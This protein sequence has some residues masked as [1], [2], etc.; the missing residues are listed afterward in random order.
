MASSV[1]EGRSPEEGRA[2]P[3]VDKD[4]II[5]GIPEHSGSLKKTGFPAAGVTMASVQ[6]STQ[7]FDGSSPL[8]APVLLTSPHSL[9]AFRRLPCAMGSSGCWRHRDH[10]RWPSLTRTVTGRGGT[11]VGVGAAVTTPGK[12]RESV[13]RGLLAGERLN[14]HT[15]VWFSCNKLF[16]KKAAA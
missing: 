5:L 16:R 4:T 6:F 9:P 10:E 14:I 13:T 7:A 11:A 12:G 1:Q 3:G 8:P 15:Q 2:T